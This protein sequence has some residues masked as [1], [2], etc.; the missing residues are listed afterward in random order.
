MCKMTAYARQAKDKGMITWVTEINL[1]ARRK[2][3]QMLA[4]MA[5]NKK[6]SKGGRKK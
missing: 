1:R 6:R 4:Q 3:G 2:S 5:K